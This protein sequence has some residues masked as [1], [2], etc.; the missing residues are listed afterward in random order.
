MEGLREQR[1]NSSN[2]QRGN[3]LDSLHECDTYKELKK[4]AKYY[5][6]QN[7]YSRLETGFNHLV[8]KIN[9][10]TD[11]LI[12]KYDE[13]IDKAFL[14]YGIDR[15]FILMHINDIRMFSFGPSEPFQ[16]VECVLY[17]RQT[18]IELSLFRVNREFYFHGND[19][20]TTLYV[21]GRITLQMNYEGHELEE[22]KK[23]I[24]EAYNNEKEN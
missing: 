3:L 5:D 8:P 22:V 11:L 24:K 16:R 2:D 18:G 1:S 15:E 21:E 4:I 20:S 9:E 17:N 23:T 14:A 7:F 19:S 6:M 13:V 10:V 12:E